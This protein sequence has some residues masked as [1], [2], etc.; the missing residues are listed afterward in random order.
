MSTSYSTSSTDYSTAHARSRPRPSTRGISRPSTARPKTGYS[1]L[2]IENQEIVCAVTEARGPS[3][4][5]GLAFVNLDTGEAVLSQMIDSQTYVRTVQKLVVFNPSTILIVATAANPKSK[6]FAIVEDHLEDIGANLTLIDRR[7]FTERTGYEYI[8]DLAFTEDVQSINTAVSGSFYAVSCFAAILKYIELDLKKTF[9][10]HSLRI[11]Y[12]PSEG[13]MMIDLATIR[14][15]ELVQNLHDAKSKDCLFGLLNRTQTPMGSRLL[16][17]SILQPTTDVETL[18]DRYDAVEELSTKEGMFFGVRSALKPFIDA[19]KILTKLIILKPQLTKEDVEQSVN[20]V[21]LLKTFVNLIRPIYNALE[22]A[23][24]NILLRIRDICAPRN[25]AAVMALISTSINEDTTFARQPLDL[26]NQRTYAVRSGVDGLLDVARLA[27]KEATDDAL[28]HLSDVGDE[29]GLQLEPKFDNNRQFYV[30]IRVSELRNQDLPGIFINPFRK[31]DWI[32]CQTLPLLKISQKISSSHSEAILLSDKAIQQ[33]VLDVREH[34]SALFKIS[35]AVAMLDML[36]SLADVVTRS[37]YVRPHLGDRLAIS[38][39]R[40]PIRER[41]EITKFVPNDVYANQQARFQIITG[42]NMSGKSTYIRSVALMTIMAQAGSFV[43][44]AYAM[45]PITRQL[46]ARVSIDDSIE[47]NASTF[48][49]EMRETAFILRNMDSSSLVIIDEL[50]RGTSTR[51]GLA[52]ALAIAEALVE[53][54]ALVWFATHFHQ[55]AVIMAERTGVVSFHLAVGDYND[56]RIEMLYRIAK[57]VLAKLV[58]LPRDVVEHAELVSNTL[59]QQ[60]REKKGGSYSIILAR[61][62]KLLLNLKD[63]LTQA[64]RGS[65]EGDGLKRWFKDLQ[66]EFIIR[67]TALDN[68]AREVERCLEK[69]NRTHLTEVEYEQ[70]ISTVGSL[71]DDS[72]A[73]FT[74]DIQTVEKRVHEIAAAETD[75]SVVGTK[76]PE[77]MLDI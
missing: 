48:A 67:M 10:S 33:L 51:D 66:K 70:P 47:A 41:I 6:L 59:E 8:H 19:D 73:R 46:F 23:Q 13:S 60:S 38:A 64:K 71:V 75:R 3:P 62:R 22:G 37:D 65:M 54:R 77:S 2:G 21:I 63:H 68:E 28:Q 32:E 61:K 52:I 18:S 24:S 26:R 44:A 45:F 9:Q 4:T 53:S 34:I 25:L 72:D 27:Y 50:G 43:P 55:L 14:S 76:Y 74:P 31:R 36:T 30:R 56:N 1:T 20:D 69:G 40:H 7:Y 15:L 42:C 17:T 49:T 35:E 57:G 5:V 11:K 29:C 39:G 58:P 16:R 12:E